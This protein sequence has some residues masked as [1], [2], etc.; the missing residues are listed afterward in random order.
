MKIAILTLPLNTNYGGILQAY[1]LQ[2]VLIRMG[3]DVTVL[4]HE[5]FW[6]RT[7]TFEK[8]L[9]YSKRFI[10]KFF[11]GKSY[12]HVTDAA[13]I[14]D[15]K[16]IGRNT[17]TFIDRYIHNRILLSLHQL[18][19]SDY[20]AYVVGSDQVWRFAYFNKTFGNDASMSDAFLDFTRGWNVKRIAYAASFGVSNLSD[21]S[22]K[23]INE[24]RRAIKSFDAVSVRE[25]SGI[26]IC[27]KYFGIRASW[28]IDP[29]LLL[30]QNDYK[31]LIN[32][33]CK[34]KVCPK[35]I[36]SYIIDPTIRKQRIREQIAKDKKLNIYYSNNERINDKSLVASERIQPSVESWIYGIAN[37]DFVITDS[38]H[39]CVF[40][41]LL[42]RQF[43][44]IG[45]ASRGM[46]RFISL[47][48]MFNLK[49]RLLV[50]EQYDELKDIDYSSIDQILNIQRKRAL[51]F[52]NNN[53]SI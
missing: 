49:D 41:I 27:Q 21:Y 37:S 24:C 16:I 12:I 32:N 30:T 17:Q 53:L 6:N 45:N 29:T 19:N 14:R 31:N 15:I 50:D 28:L 44:V 47:L 20:D 8:P 5:S 3:H 13:Y 23:D 46:D 2:T 4:N 51:E 9:V 38:F 42:H 22:E 18:K 39:A 52:L 43:V 33:N 35:Y 7:K 48:E 25:K 40:S 26:D 1:A 36:F 11:L 10:K 34:I